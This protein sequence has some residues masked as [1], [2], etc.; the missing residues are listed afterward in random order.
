VTQASLAVVP[1]TLTWLPSVR[2]RVTVAGQDV[3][4]GTASVVAPGP[5]PVTL[6][7]DAR[8]PGTRVEATL[9]L[10]VEVRGDGPTTV[11]VG[12]PLPALLSSRGRTLG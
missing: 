3:P 8:A 2:W 6:R 1:P 10:T 12:S 4:P 9:E 7:V 5:V 11:V